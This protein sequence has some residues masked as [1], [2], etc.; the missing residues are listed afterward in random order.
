MAWFDLQFR[1]QPSRARHRPRR[2]LKA[3]LLP[4]FEVRVFNLFLFTV[5]FS[6][7]MVMLCCA[8]F[9]GN[10]LHDFVTS[11]YFELL[12]YEIV[13]AQDGLQQELAA[14]YLQ[15][16]R[17]KNLMRLDLEKIERQLSR[18]PRISRASVKSLPPNAV[19]VS[20]KERKP[21]AIVACTSLYFIDEERMV[22]DTVTP[23]EDQ[24]C[25]LPF[26]TG[27]DSY[28]ISMGDQ[29]NSEQPH[30][31]Q[32]VIETIQQLEEVSPLLA[33]RISEYAIGDQ[34]A[35]TLT[36]RDGLEVRFGDEHP[37][38]QMAVLE[39][40]LN[41]TGQTLQ[42]EYIDLRFEGQLVYLPKK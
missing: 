17:H 34:G 27:I 25:N 29:V 13:G 12:E 5:R 22:I 30:S 19:K 28:E 21:L 15:P 42:C 39:T 35:I 33:Q 23:G 18:H 41:T 3:R 7:F 10:K 14:L 24:F 31:L 1:S 40:F 11:D 6:V 2:R 9:F 4:R 26:I 38:K 8:L 32:N 37:L 20:V 16:E 36:M